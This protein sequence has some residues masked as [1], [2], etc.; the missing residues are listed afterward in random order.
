MANFKK[1]FK[2]GVDAMMA[3]DDKS[4]G[5]RYRT[6]W[7]GVRCTQCGGESFSSGSAMLNTAAMTLVGLDWLNK[8][9]I[10]LVCVRCSA[11]HWFAESVTELED[12]KS[13]AGQGP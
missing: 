10:V 9:A 3:H 2:A 8:S 13:D 4:S 6:D 5:S 12:I 7:G 11:I 1:A